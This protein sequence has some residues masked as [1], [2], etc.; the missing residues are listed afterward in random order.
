MRSLQNGELSLNAQQEKDQG[1]NGNEKILQ[2]VPGAYAPQ[3][4]E[5]E[6]GFHWREGGA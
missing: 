1:K 4:G 2:E 6:I 5:R 3:R